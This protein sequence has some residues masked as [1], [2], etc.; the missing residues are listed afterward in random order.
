MNSDLRLQP[1]IKRLRHSHM[2]FNYPKLV[3]HVNLLNWYYPKNFLISFI[4]RIREPWQ[5]RNYFFNI[6]LLQSDSQFPISPLM[7]PRT[8]WS[9]YRS[10]TNNLFSSF[11][12]NIHV[13]NPYIKID[14]ITALLSQVLV[15]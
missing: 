12:D 7:G 11:R 2:V 6:F 5:L 8:F 1:R 3:R 9:I 10:A 13:S 14:L 15:V 4:K